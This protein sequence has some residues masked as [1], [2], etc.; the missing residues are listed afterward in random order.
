MRI[1]IALIRKETLQIF[2]DPSAIL[3]AF[4]LPLILLF[5]FGYGV[6]LDSNK[7]R[8]GV[9]VENSTQET[10]SL[11]RAFT[12]S[13]FLEV[14]L[15]K[16]R[17][18][19]KQQM[20]SGD[21]RGLVVIPQNFTINAALGQKSIPI[22]IITD[23]SEP[24]I[25]SFVTSYVHEVLNIWANH[26][27]ED[28]GILLDQT[29]KIKSR[30]WYNP[31]LRSRYF[32]IPGSIA[33][34][35]TIIGTLLTALVI[36]REWERGTMEALMSTPASMLQIMLSKLITYFILGIGSMMLCWAIAVFWY[37]IP[38]RGSFLLL[39]I[40]SSIFL[41]G[42]LGQGLLIS[43]TTKDQFIASQAA[44]MSAFLPAFMLSGF[45]YEIS[46]MPKPIQWLTHIFPARY[47]VS[48]LQTLFLTGNILPLLVPCAFFM[49]LIGF[50]FLILTSLKMKKRLDI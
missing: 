44:L 29:I 35:M 39:L 8:I 24:N 1:L 16:D 11:L 19:L 28:K 3:I 12:N 4:V 41:L 5:V 13:P 21:L 38:F 50:I 31:E 26:R 14:T 2:R 47:F 10:E 48:S 40:V 45:L 36:A 17:R 15:S 27:S 46:S 22:Q 33:I 42:A 25:A 43:C 30:F 32:L 23:G 9:V 7:V 34:V 37:E 6:N 49:A 18:H 20:I